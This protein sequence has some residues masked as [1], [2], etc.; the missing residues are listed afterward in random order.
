LKVRI[1]VADSDRVVEVEAE[2]GTAIKKEVDEAFKAGQP[3]LWF[4][5]TKHRLIGIPTGKVAYVEI[6]Q[7]LGERSVGFS[8]GVGG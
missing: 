4:E 7:Q 1:G 3:I 8:A 2:D 6:D 5:D